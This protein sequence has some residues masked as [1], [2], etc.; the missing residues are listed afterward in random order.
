MMGSGESITF[1]RR[2]LFRIVT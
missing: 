1:E 2:S